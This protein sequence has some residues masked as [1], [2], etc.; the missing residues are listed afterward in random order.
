M[1]TCPGST[2]DDRCQSDDLCLDNPPSLSRL[3]APVRLALLQG[4]DKTTCLRNWNV[5]YGFLTSSCFAV[6]PQLAWSPCQRPPL[7]PSCIQTR[8]WTVTMGRTAFRGRSRS[9]DISCG[10]KM[11]PSGM[12]RDQPGARSN[13][14]SCYSD[15]GGGELKAT[16]TNRNKPAL[17]VALLRTTLFLPLQG[18]FNTSTSQLCRQDGGYRSCA[19]VVLL[20]LKRHCIGHSVLS[21]WAILEGNIT[22]IHWELGWPLWFKW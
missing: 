10:P 22:F 5:A 21:H 12:A 13:G 1:P 6:F 16:F 14:K 19:H 3:N 11:A 4:K 7:L 17:T 8:I 18:S 15:G 20:S 2:R 9:A